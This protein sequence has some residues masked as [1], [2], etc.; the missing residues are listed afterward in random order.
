MTRAAIAKCLVWSSAVVPLNP[1][2]NGGTRRGEGAEVMLPDTLLFETAE[3][4]FDETVLF[5]G[6]GGDELLTQAVIAA[7][8]TKTPALKDQA[9]VAT[10]HWGGTF[11]TQSAETSQA[12]LLEGTLGFL[13]TATQRELITSHFAVVAIDNRSQMAPAVGTARHMRHVHRPPLIA[14]LRATSKS[15]SPRPRRRRALMNQPAFDRQ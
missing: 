10:H 9:I 5:R 6:V 1:L 12:G 15:V 11:R 8:G 13:G 14:M 2:S 3:E 4:A 7:S